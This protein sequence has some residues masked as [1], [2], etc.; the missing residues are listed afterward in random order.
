MFLCWPCCFFVIVLIVFV[1]IVVLFQILCQ[2]EGPFTGQQYHNV[3]FLSQYN[4]LCFITE[5]G[6]FCEIVSLSIHNILY[7]L[8]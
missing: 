1:V 4:I 7:M 3:F 8:I 6:W 2:F 5:N